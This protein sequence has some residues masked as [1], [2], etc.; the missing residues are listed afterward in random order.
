MTRRPHVDQLHNE[1][2]RRPSELADKPRRI[3]E[4]MLRAA[5]PAGLE[6]SDGARRKIAGIGNLLD[7]RLDA[8]RQMLIRFCAIS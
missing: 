6:G 2:H 8:Q 1:R 7:E 3:A 5:N 4:A